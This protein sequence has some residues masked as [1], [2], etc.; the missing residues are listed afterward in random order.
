MARNNYRTDEANVK[1]QLNFSLIRRLFK[2]VLPHK[3]KFAIGAVLLVINVL[4]ALVWP[5]TIQWLI[6]N[7]L[8]EGG[9]FEN[10]VSVLVW[11]VV[12][13]FAILVTDIV[14]S[15]FRSIIIT[16]LGQMVV[17]DIRKDIFNHLQSLSFRYFD[18]R[19]A[20]KI[21]QNVTT[22]VDTLAGL[23]S[24]QIIKLAVD[25]LTLIFIF[26]ML[27]Q[28]SVR[29]TLLSFVVLIPLM[30][31][32]TLIRNKSKALSRPQRAKSSNREAYIHESV[33]GIYTTQAFSHQNASEKE[34]DRLSIE[35]NDVVIKRSL[36]T[37]LLAPS[38]DIFSNLGKILV[39]FIAVLFIADGTDNMTLG[40]LTAFITYLAN[41]WSPITSFA[42]FFEQLAGATSN[43]EHIFE[44]LDTQSELIEKPD[45]I[46][47]P[48]IK[49]YVEY[50]NV[51]FGYEEGINVFE[52]VSFTVSPGEM[53]A[54]VGPTG[55]GKTTMVSLL[56]RFYDACSGS[57]K[58]DGIDV[59]DVTLKSLRTQIGI[60]M[61]DAF[62]FSGTIIDNIRYGNP[63]A[64]DEECIAAAKLVYA[65]DFI[66]DFP[67]GYYTTLTEGGDMLS[68]GQKQLISFARVII[69][70]P[71]ILVLDEATSNIDT[72]TELLIQKALDKIISGRTSFV[73]AHRLSTIRNADRIMC[74]ANNTIAESGSHEE[75]MARKGIYYNLNMS[76]I[77]VL[78][79]E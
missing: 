24:S 45:A 34:F 23:L 22:Y 18:D 70:N 55:S 20:G 78:T 67:R 73:I 76:Q 10:N 42:T 56:S 57:V 53:I 46:E 52:N 35:L 14:L 21:L 44:T 48:A 47:M 15:A 64:T 61:Q 27:L 51:T 41:F 43:I 28:M 59:K 60:I 69:S 65:D 63:S 8:T 4:V 72:H 32:L 5:K 25:S 16:K 11:V 7:V 79:E 77:N 50:D 17:Y 30:I 33:M 6:D 39:Y 66:K 74:I 3:N 9:A 58:I 29:L 13:V 36:V 71:K 37:N 12:I 2:Y 19:S 49:G 40:V 38:I 68:A 31:V 62:I 1:Q 54:F 26:I 75:L